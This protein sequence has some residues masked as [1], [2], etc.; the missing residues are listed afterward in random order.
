MSSQVV[1]DLAAEQLSLQSAFDP[2]NATVLGVPGYDAQLADP[3]VGWEQELRARAARV[4]DRAAAVDPSAISEDEAITAAVVIQQA[5]ALIDRIDA[6]MVEYSVTDLQFAGPAAALLTYL[7]MAT[8]S[9]QAQADAFLERLR[10]VP[11][12]LARVADRHRLGATAG[13]LPVRRLLEAAVAHLDRYLADPA[14]DPLL[15]PLPSDPGNV[16]TA[17]R[18]DLVENLARPAIAKYRAVLAD[19]LAD[20]ARTDERPGLCWLPGG[21]AAYVALSRVHTT[22]DRTPDESHRLG[23][24][25]IAGLRQEY[26]ALGKRV[27]GITDQSEVFRRLTTDPAMRWANGEEVLAHARAAIQRAEA[28]LPSFFGVLP[29]QHCQV[30]PVPAADAPG[31]PPGYYFQPSLDGERAGIYYANTFQAHERDR[32]VSEAIAFHEAVPGH[33]MQLTIA[34]E[35]AELPLLRRF[36]NV[37]GSIEG[38]GLYVERLAD[39]MGLYSDDVARL[40]MLAM[41]SLRGARLVVDTGIHAKGWTRDKAI[42]YMMEN[43]PLSALVIRQEVDRYIGFPA[44][45][46]SYMTGRLEIQRIRAQAEQRLG[47]RFDIRAFHDLVL[48]NAPLPLNVLDQLATQWDGATL[49]PDSSMASRNDM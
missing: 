13:R 46:L 38:W 34:V 11:A 42:A 31:A 32:F 37:N 41:D 35:R 36:A 18:A 49:A 27:F 14:G 19:E 23:L 17:R 43:T 48:V 26:A 16:F 1:R 7:P 4:A 15:R 47:P 10:G 40:G 33:H 30:L 20:H 5:S 22:I 21:D 45:A 12:Y 29:A 6:G 28:A 24:D 44:Q 9:T 8:L 3:S 39:E 2:L 25:V